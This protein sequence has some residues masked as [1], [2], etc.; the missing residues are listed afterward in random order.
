MLG[1]VLFWLFIGERR[2]VLQYGWEGHK[3]YWGRH[4]IFSLSFLLLRTLCRIRQKNPSSS[5][6]RISLA[7]SQHEPTGAG[8]LMLFLPSRNSATEN[9]QNVISAVQMYPG[10]TVK[11]PVILK[12]CL[13]RC[14][15]LSDYTC[16]LGSDS[17]RP[18]W[19]WQHGVPRE[20]L[21]AV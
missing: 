16:Y 15:S 20:R 17:N 18:Q 7:Q 3:K 11:L 14:V 10:F 12:S 8:A 19:L 21:T 1:C 6:I 5:V 4:I 9:T 2:L 13:T